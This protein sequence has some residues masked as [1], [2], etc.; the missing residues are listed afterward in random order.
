MRTS[1]LLG[2][3]RRTLGRL[4]DGDRAAFTPQQLADV[5]VCLSETA[6]RGSTAEERD[7]ATAWLEDAARSDHQVAQQPP[8]LK[9][10]SAVRSLTS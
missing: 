1:T 9:R 2:L 7:A 8:A 6:S 10:P 4:V 3:S 5:R